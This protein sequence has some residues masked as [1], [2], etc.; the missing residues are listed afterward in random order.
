LQ[1]EL[2]SAEVKAEEELA[3]A[4]AKAEEALVEMEELKNL[5]LAATK[6]ELHSLV[7][8][9]EAAVESAESS[10]ASLKV[11]AVV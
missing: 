9:H 4:H 3:A 1:T 5:E 7:A 10:M 8:I 2:A 11:T 6:E